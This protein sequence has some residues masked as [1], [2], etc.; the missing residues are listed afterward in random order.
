M[1]TNYYIK[2]KERKVNQPDLHIGKNSAGWEFSFQGYEE[3]K[4]YG[5]PKLKSKKEWFEYMFLNS[6][7]IYDEYNQHIAFNKIVELINGSRNQES[8]LNHFNEIKARNDIEGLKYV[9]NDEEEFTISMS[10][11]D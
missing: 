9:F 2:H 11:F 5:T 6:E 4:Y 10:D 3:N 1:G 8:A 7:L